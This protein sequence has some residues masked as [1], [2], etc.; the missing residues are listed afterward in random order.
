MY[1]TELNSALPFFFSMEKSFFFA[2]LTQLKCS[3]KIIPIHGKINWVIYFINEHIE[4]L[5]T[6]LLSKG[7]LISKANFL[8]LN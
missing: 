6:V 4:L 1:F 2:E 5:V 7:Q 8:V 3:H